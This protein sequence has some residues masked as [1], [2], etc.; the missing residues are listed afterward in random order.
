M[1][2]WIFARND[3]AMK[4]KEYDFR[5]IK[6][7]MQSELCLRPASW[8][9]KSLNLSGLFSSKGSEWS[10]LRLLLTLV[11]FTVSWFW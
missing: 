10:I 5:F 4:G 7:E 3:K 1:N 2:L 6:T 9:G 11:S 8:F